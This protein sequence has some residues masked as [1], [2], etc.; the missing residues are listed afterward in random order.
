MTI[1][2][3]EIASCELSLDDLWDAAPENIGIFEP[4]N[5]FHLPESARLYLEHA[6]APGTRLAAAVRLTMHGEIKLNGHWLP[7]TAEQVIRQGRGFLWSATVMQHGVPIRGSDRLLD[8][9]GEMHWKLFGR[10][11]VQDA[12]GPN[13]TRSE[14]GRLHTESVWLPS[15]LCASDVRWTETESGP[16]AQMTTL[17]EKSDLALELE[18][19][20][21]VRAASLMRWGNPKVAAFYDVPF[22]GIFDEE[23]TFD[24]YTIPTRVRV[25]WHFGTD[26]FETDGEFFTATI[27]SAT[28][29]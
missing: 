18:D 4:Q 14:V 29:R 17:G 19:S 5:F 21:R 3:N 1:E 27:D 15:M 10:F 12:S 24:G 28:F 23:R 16:C 13:V 26:R 8:G 6:I 9:V 20:G 25:G 2:M 7:F 11:S 22:G